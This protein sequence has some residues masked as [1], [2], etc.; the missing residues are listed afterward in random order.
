MLAGGI[1]WPLWVGEGKC[2]CDGHGGSGGARL[3]GSVEVG[4]GYVV[5]A[6]VTILGLEFHLHSSEGGYGRRQQLR[7]HGLGLESS[8][9]LLMVF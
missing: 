1:I 5:Y 8:W 3:S 4:E 7:A 9:N 2:F 6:V